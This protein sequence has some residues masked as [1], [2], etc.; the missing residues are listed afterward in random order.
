[1]VGST[2][3]AGIRIFIRVS[4]SRVESTRVTDLTTR[5]SAFL[6]DAGVMSLLSSRVTSPRVE[7]NCLAFDGLV[8]DD[9]HIKE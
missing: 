1:M 6:I 5:Q 2:R 7:K 4:L 9:F 8:S 3:G